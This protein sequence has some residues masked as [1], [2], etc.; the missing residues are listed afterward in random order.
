MAVAACSGEDG[1]VGPAGEQGEQGEQGDPGPEGPQG[2]QGP[3]G[4][5]GEQGEPGQP[6]GGAAIA[7][8]ATYIPLQWEP[9]TVPI[10]D[11]EKREVLAS[12]WASRLGRTADIGYHTLARSG[13]EFDDAVFGQMLDQNGDPIVNDDESE[14]IS[15]AMDFSS[16]LPVGDKLFAVTHFESRPGG[17]YLSELEQDESGELSIV[18]TQNVDFSEWG[19]L[20]VP[21]AGSVTPWGTHLGSEEYPPDARAFDT[22]DFEA[23]AE[24]SG[25]LEGDIRAV[26]RYF[27][28]DSVDSTLADYKEVMNPY[29]Y[30]YPVQIAVEDD[31][32]YEVTKH[33]SM[34]RRAL[35]IAYVMPD[36]KTVYLTDDGTNTGLYM[37]LADKAGDLSAGKL[38]AAKWI[39]TSAVGAGSADIQWIAL[40]SA[41]DAELY[42]M[43]YKDD[44][45]FSDIFTVGEP[46]DEVTCADDFLPSIYLGVFEC[47]QVNDGMETA[48]AFL[49]SGRYASMLGATLEFRK[50]EGITFDPMSNTLYLA[51]SEVGKAM[52]AGSDS[53]AGG[54]DHIQLAEENP[55]G[56]VYA[57]DV[58]PN[59]E[60]GSEYTAMNFRAFVEGTPIE[61]AEDSP[62]ANNTCSINGIANPD[63]VTFIPEHSTLVIGEDTGSGHQN[64]AIWAYDV[65]GRKLTRILTTPYGSE[66][67]SPYWYTNINGFAYLAGVVQHPYGESDEDKSTGADD[68]RA[69]TGYVGPIPAMQ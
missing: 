65:V 49:E 17:M 34:G 66:T 58:S 61:Y 30:G 26:G 60:T 45:Q 22:D 55:C 6:G 29:F 52:L 39:Q 57:L 11:D 47:L 3:Q 2:E 44:I 64:D 14:F 40:G 5:Q 12:G 46:V 59:G 51:M 15:N 43:I 24:I 42:D 68:E 8:G 21:C 32:S 31:G 69:Y 67:T 37:Y 35:E 1:A 18:N 62:Y 16:I 36:E 13:D 54:P 53:D 48:A 4:D 19:G 28:L 20:W 33:L 10:S 56:A 63:N 27:G 23:A 50:E 9:V 38:F 7:P 25:F 41:S